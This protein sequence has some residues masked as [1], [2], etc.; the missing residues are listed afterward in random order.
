VLFA[1]CDQPLPHCPY[2]LARHPRPTCDKCRQAT[3]NMMKQFKLPYIRLSDYVSTEEIARVHSEIMRTAHMDLLE[4]RENSYEVG[5]ISN[6][7]LKY[8][9]FGEVEFNATTFDVFTRILQGN[10]LIYRFAERLLLDYDPKVVVTNNGQMFHTRAGYTCFTSHGIRTITWDGYPPFEDSFIFSQVE[11]SVLGY[12]DKAIWAAEKVNPLTHEQEYNVNNF[13]AGWRKGTIGDINYHPTPETSADGLRQRLHI[14]DHKKTFLAFTNV[15]WDSSCLDRDVGFNGMMEWV[16]ALIDWFV[17]NEADS[18]LVVRVHPAE[19]KLPEWAHTVFGVEQC[20]RQKYETLP[21]NIV[22]VGPEDDAYSYTL[23]KI[24]DAVGVYTT[25]LGYELAVQGRKVWVAGEVYYREHGF[26]LDVANRQHMYELLEKTWDRD[27][28][29]SEQEL[30][31]KFT[32]L[33]FFRQIIRIPFLHRTKIEYL[34]RPYFKDLKFL[35]P[36][37]DPMFGTLVDRVIDGKPFLDIPAETTAEW[38]DV[39]I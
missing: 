1:V 27:L 9:Y 5:R 34:T 29:P 3:V 11:P 26:T 12:V 17:R 14:A 2:E 19:K 37:R 32:Y 22:I 24:A 39:P 18:Q 10:L 15:I 8:Y 28:T 30:A 21:D 13:L 7:L 38:T 25:S 20:I 35:W 4:L 36:Q 16:Y 31:V 6:E 33:R 23:A